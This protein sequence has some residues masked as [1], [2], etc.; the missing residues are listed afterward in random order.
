[1]VVVHFI[2]TCIICM[3]LCKTLHPLLAH[4]ISHQLCEAGQGTHIDF[5]ST[6]HPAPCQMPSS[7]YLVDFTQSI[8]ILVSVLRQPVLCPGGTAMNKHKNPCLGRIH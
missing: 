5:A 8:H 4:W 7:Y 1:M 3:T 6:L 2:M